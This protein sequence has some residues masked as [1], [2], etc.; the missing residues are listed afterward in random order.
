MRRI[1]LIA[2]LGW[3]LAGCGSYSPPI[4]PL[5]TQ[6]PT[7]SV[8][9]TASPSPALEGQ[10]VTLTGTVTVAPAAFNTLSLAGAT[11]QF[12]NG[13][14]SLGTASL[15]ANNQATLSTPLPAGTDSITAR[16]S[17]TAAVAAATSSPISVTVLANTTTTVQT[18]A[19]PSG[20]TQSVTFTATVGSVDVTGTPTGTVTFVVDNISQT[21]TAL[22]GGKATLITS[23][24]ANGSHS[25]GAIYSGD[26][27]FATST[28]TALSQVVNLDNSH[29]SLQSSAAP[30]SSGQNVTFTAT[31]S[32]VNLG[33]TPTGTV[34]FTVDGTQ[35]GQPVTL[36]AGQASFSD[37]NLTS[38][39]SPHTIGATYNGSAIF[40]TSTT[41]L[42]QTVNAAL[43]QFAYV[44]TS[45]AQ[46]GIDLFTVGSAGTL[47]AATTE[48]QAT[49]GPCSGLAVTPNGAFVVAVRN[50]GGV[51]T[52]QSFAVN[53]TT[54]ALTQVAQTT[55]ATVSGANG[56]IALDPSGTLG[57]V[58]TASQVVPFRLG[59]T[60]QIAVGAGVNSNN[61]VNVAAAVG[62]LGIAV[63]GGSDVVV[64]GTNSQ[65]VNTF[66]LT[67]SG[68]V[69][70]LGTGVF[71]Q[72]DVTGSCV[73][74]AVLGDGSTGL[75]GGTFSGIIGNEGNTFPLSLTGTAVTVGTGGTTFQGGQMLATTIANVPGFANPLALAV[76]QVSNGLDVFGLTTT[77]TTQTAL[78]GTFSLNLAGAS[79]ATIL[80]P[81]AGHGA[82][83][84]GLVVANGGSAATQGVFPLTLS[85]TTG[86]AAGSIV[87]DTAAPASGPNTIGTVSLFQ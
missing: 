76:S 84:L 37:A 10:S 29:T 11:V 13:T 28:A 20:A 2:L 40:G 60:G 87:T 32:A 81:V 26:A 52:L 54:G 22:A 47:A 33:G 12:L 48:G 58:G 17:G 7:A 50:V 34:T 36:V 39:G 4:L 46:N 43:F 5:A 70:T 83:N 63:N 19:N 25:I 18:S 35:Q 3:L 23:A 9:V 79:A 64:T 21:P 57:A 15:G 44:A 53:P 61:G 8:T 56:S 16:F 77:S 80:V 82:V 31:V 68:G 51:Q 14:T 24:L 62:E 66:T 42:Q 72:G 49:G 78:P 55:T 59:T 65:M 75:L 30:S 85:S 27:T 45:G 73:A 71:T 1:W 86:L 67:L 69:P 6:A 41:S 38:V 74:A